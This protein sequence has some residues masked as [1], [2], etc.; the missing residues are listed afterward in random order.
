MTFL[1]PSS[2]SI[3]SFNLFLF[4]LVVTQEAVVNYC[5]DCGDLFEE[6]ELSTCEHSIV[7]RCPECFRSYHDTL[8]VALC[9]SGGEQNGIGDKEDPDRKIYN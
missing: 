6:E 3:Y 5:T 4:Y 2:A 7:E 9:K 8:K 1:I